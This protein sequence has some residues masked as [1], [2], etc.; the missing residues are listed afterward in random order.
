MKS[1]LI[2]TALLL[3]NFLVCFSQEK[4]KQTENIVSQ[5][6]EISEQEINERIKILQT[7]LLC[8]PNQSDRCVTDNRWNNCAQFEKWL[9]TAPRG[10]KERNMKC[11]QGIPGGGILLEYQEINKQ[12]ARKINKAN[13]NLNKN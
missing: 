8:K 11:I 10:A 9:E 1:K 4:E 3:F 13:I 7:I 12:K 2:F 5:K 6:T